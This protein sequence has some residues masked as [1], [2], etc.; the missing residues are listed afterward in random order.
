M[1]S[2]VP[3]WNR[4]GCRY[5]IVELKNENDMTEKEATHYCQR[6]GYAFGNI[7]LCGKH[8][9]IELQK[10]EVPKLGM[11]ESDLVT[12]IGQDANP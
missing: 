6:G 5:C 3:D 1:K 4:H 9:T 2:I 7:W 11:L 10:L 8:Y 12:D